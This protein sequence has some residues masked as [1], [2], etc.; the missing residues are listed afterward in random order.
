MQPPESVQPDPLVTAVKTQGVR[1]DRAIA[2]W[3][4]LS[5]SAVLR[6]LDQA[7]VAV[8]GR[9]MKRGNKGDLL[10]LGDRISLDPA[11]AAGEAPLADSRLAVTVLARGEGWL[12]VEKS[13]GVPV[14]PHVLDETGTVLNAVV[15][16]HPEIVGVGEGGLRSGV[17]HRLDNDTSGVLLLA[18]RHETWLVLRKAFSRRRIRKRYLALVDGA[19]DERGQSRR[20]LRIARHQPAHVV[21]EPEGEGTEGA[22]TCSL[23]WTRVER[24]GERA[25][26]IEV[27][28]H[29]G[30]LHQVR[31]MMNAMGHPVLGDRVYGRATTGT[32]AP[33]QMLHARSLGYDQIDARAPI[34]EDMQRVMQALRG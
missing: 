15:A 26:L 17:V 22:R 29:T 16:M 14:R 21:V 18:T 10:A 27:D 2:D 23:G 3:R 1:L 19:I 4:G 31:A 28:L 5:R 34:P 20:D 30:F 6:L 8:N 33:R 11:Y 12:A 9:A 13:A 24:F 32:V 25:S 7:A